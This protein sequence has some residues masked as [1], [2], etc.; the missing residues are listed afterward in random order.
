MSLE[1]TQ[2]TMDAYMDAL[3]TGGDFGQYF[4]DDVVWTTMENGQ[5]VRGRE[6]VR[7]FIAGFHTQSF[8][9]HPELRSLTITDG[10]A[11]LEADFV[12]VH[13]REL[14][15][16]PPTGA[17]VRLP[18]SIFYDLDDAGISALRA[19]IPLREMM[20]QLEAARSDAA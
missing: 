17:E 19:Y 9:A 20:A 18:Y 15:G 4:T 10:R 3:L 16:I 14:A 2:Q 6:A 7:D 11:A 1:S 8:D 13:V 5:E 12:G